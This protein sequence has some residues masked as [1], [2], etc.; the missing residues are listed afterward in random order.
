[1]KKTSVVA[2][3]NSDETQY[4]C[5]PYFAPLLLNEVSG[6]NQDTGKKSSFLR[7]YLFH[8]FDVEKIRIIKLHADRCDTD[9]IDYERKVAELSSFWRRTEGRVLL[10]AI[11]FIAG[12]GTTIGI[13]HAIRS[14]F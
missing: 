9:L 11:G 12:V 8:R 1:M 4:D 13:V 2:M 3:S 14:D 5:P 6:I 7:G 10:I